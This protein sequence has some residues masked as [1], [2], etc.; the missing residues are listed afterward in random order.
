MLNE[1]L[2]VNQKINYTPLNLFSTLFNIV[3][4]ETDIRGYW[5]DKKGKLYID[6]IELKTYSIIQ[7]L[8]FR[9]AKNNLFRNGE[10]CIFYKNKFNEGVIEYR[11]KSKI[12]L[13]NRIA[14]I[15]NSKPSKDYIKALLNNHNGLTIYKIDNGKYLIEIYKA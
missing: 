10:D 3:S 9:S 11:T 14:I 6:N 2:L 15:E 12:V 5:Q 7:N 8:E 1:L 4:H 13:R